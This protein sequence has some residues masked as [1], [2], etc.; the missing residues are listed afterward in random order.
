[1]PGIVVTLLLLLGLAGC[2]SM[3]A[4]DSEV[5]A[6]AAPGAAAVLRSG[7]SYR[8][9]RLPSQQSDPGRQQAL[10]LAADLAL[11]RIGL[12]AMGQGQQADLG[13]MLSVQSGTWVRDDEGNLFPAGQAGPRM[14]IGIGLGTAGSGLA[15][16]M[17][18]TYL[19]RHQLVLLMRDLRSGLIAYEAR[20]WHEGPWP[21][22]EVLLPVMLDAA[23]QGFPSPPPGRRL[24]RTEVPR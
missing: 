16:S 23:L 18:L 21:D 5:L 22:R 4:I 10:E 20:A 8:Y 1:M 19:Y 3:R 17:P 2:G 15:L 13:V 14:R 12:R 24:V 11:A 6:E 9:E 7:A